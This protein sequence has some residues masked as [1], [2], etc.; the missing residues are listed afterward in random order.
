[1]EPSREATGS[2]DQAKCAQLEEEEEEFGSNKVCI[3]L[4]TL[5]GAKQL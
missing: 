5:P 1:M 3:H 2:N 4:P